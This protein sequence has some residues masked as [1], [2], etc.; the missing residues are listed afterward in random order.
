MNA[1]VTTSTPVTLLASQ[2]KNSKI[3]NAA[4]DVALN[5][6]RNFDYMHFVPINDNQLSLFEGSQDTY[7]TWFLSENE[8]D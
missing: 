8:L 2:V 1:I 6:A 5:E 4:L 7:W 3:V